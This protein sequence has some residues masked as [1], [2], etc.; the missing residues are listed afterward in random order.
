MRIVN[1][2]NKTV[3]FFTK[4]VGMKKRTRRGWKKMYVKHT[5]WKRSK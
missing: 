2:F 4:A 3:H 5:S 1:P